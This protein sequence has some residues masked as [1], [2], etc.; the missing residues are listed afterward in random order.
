MELYVS[1]PGGTL[2]GDAGAVRATSHK[3]IFT[4]FVFARVDT[5]TRHCPG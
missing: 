4:H 2:A 3:A 5:A 1:C